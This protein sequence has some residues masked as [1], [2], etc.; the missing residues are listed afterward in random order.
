MISVDI[1]N[2]PMNKSRVKRKY[3]QFM[4]F[5][6]RVCTKK[7]IKHKMIS[8]E[9]YHRSTRENSYPI[10]RKYENKC[11]MNVIR[12]CVDNNMLYYMHAWHIKT[13]FYRVEVSKQEQKIAI[14]KF[15]FSYF[16]VD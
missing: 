16:V 1:Q 10:S 5:R 3:N 14:I 8:P 7:F 2:N 6:C 4:L 13:E 15:Y 9:T 12:V 11:Y